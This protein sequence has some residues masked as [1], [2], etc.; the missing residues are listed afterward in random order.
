MVEEEKERLDHRYQSPITNKEH[1]CG[2][3][4]RAIGQTYWEKEEKADV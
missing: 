1:V 4:G 3:F 2:K